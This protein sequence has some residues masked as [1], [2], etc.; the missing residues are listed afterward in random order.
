M[1]I[2]ILSQ[3]P[4]RGCFRLSLFPLSLATLLRRGRVDVWALF[5]DHATTSAA[6]VDE[7]ATTWDASR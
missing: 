5:V 7:G 6:A 3:S 2:D 4:L 1:P